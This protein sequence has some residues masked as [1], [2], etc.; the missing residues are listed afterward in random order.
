MKRTHL[1]ATL[2]LLIVATATSCYNLAPENLMGTHSSADI[3]KGD[4]NVLNIDSLVDYIRSIHLEHYTNYSPSTWG[5]V[6]TEYRYNGKH[7]KRVRID[8]DLYRKPEMDYLQIGNST[9]SLLHEWYEYQ[10]EREKRAQHVYDVLVNLCKSLS[11]EVD[12]SNSSMWESHHDGIDS[13]QYNIALREYP[14]GD[15]LTRWNGRRGTSFSQ[16]PEIVRF[17]YDDDLPTRYNG[18]DPE[19]TA[20]LATKGFGTFFYTYTP[21]SVPDETHELINKKEFAKLIKPIL[22]QKGIEKR[23]IYIRRDINCP[24]GPE[25][26]NYSY[27]RVGYRTYNQLT[28]DSETKGTVYKLQSV[29]QAEEVIHLLN[30]VI[31]KYLDQHPH[32]F[33]SFHPD[34]TMPRWGRYSSGS[35]YYEPYF[36]MEQHTTIQ[37]DCTILIHNYLTDYY[38]LV[39][40]TVGDL[41]LPR[42]WPFMKSWENGQIIYEKKDKL[43][44]FVQDEDKKLVTPLDY[45]G[46]G[47][48]DQYTLGHWTEF[49]KPQKKNKK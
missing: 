35:G 1:K 34:V 27:T 49:D 36:T 46:F 24:V 33:Y 30:E 48:S 38:L 23:D 43:S 22:N 44:P 41:W 9:D 14:Q 32:L 4:G 12:V 16:A 25:M 37:E 19:K 18:L 39:L 40:N 29:E 28:T 13:I 2:A 10:Q 42:E 6:E 45:V 21:D 26:G 5:L 11:H 7:T 15:T 8:C 3:Y 20:M 31:W 47:A 17:Y